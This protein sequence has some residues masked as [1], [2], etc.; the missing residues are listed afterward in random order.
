MRAT[1]TKQQGLEIS[2]ST[3]ANQH[4]KAVFDAYLCVCECAL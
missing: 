2:V 3:L 4:K 1:F